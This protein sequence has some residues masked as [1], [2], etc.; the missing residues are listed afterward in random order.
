M[1]NISG[2]NLAGVVKVNRGDT[3]IAF[4]A[5]EALENRTEEQ[6]EF[7]QSL[8]SILILLFTKKDHN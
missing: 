4:K 6:I 7:L 3:A 8:V 5:A 1:Q 2:F